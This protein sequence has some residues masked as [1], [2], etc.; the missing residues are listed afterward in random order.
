MKKS[1]N[2]AQLKLRHILTLRGG[3]AARFQFPFS[4]NPLSD[5]PSST[6]TTTNTALND[7]HNNFSSLLPFIIIPSLPQIIFMT[8]ISFAIAEIFN[9]C[10]MFYDEDG[11]E[12]SYRASQF[13]QSHD[14]VES[15]LK[16]ISLNVMDWVMYNLNEEGDLFHLPTCK[17]RIEALF[18][19]NLEG[20][21]GDAH[22]GLNHAYYKLK[23]SMALK[24]KFAI[25]STLGMVLHSG[26]LW[27]A[28]V[29]ITTYLLSEISENVI[30]NHDMDEMQ[31]QK[32]DGESNYHNYRR[33][34][35]YTIQDF[36]YENVDDEY[37][38][39]IEETLDFAFESCDTIQILI[40]RYLRICNSKLKWLRLKVRSVLTSPIG[41]L[42]KIWNGSWLDNE[43]TLIA[44]FIFGL[45]LASL[46]SDTL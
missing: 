30:S 16:D 35:K 45:V 36:F 12:A 7:Q 33:K 39:Q 17:R 25:G 15:A 20:G 43:E 18:N 9:S 2:I 42:E 31:K 4:K 26:T 23:S 34:G 28:K 37:K 10:N 24:H 3:A 22:G 41:S 6:L 19:F 1:P 21:D 11:I 38:E 46:S 5:M 29:F 32:K 44:G 8:G 14:N 13:I 40:F 27:I